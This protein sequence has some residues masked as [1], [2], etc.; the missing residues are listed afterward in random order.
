VWW[1]DDIIDGGAGDDT[2]AGV[3]TAELHNLDLR[4]LS[5]S[6]LIAY[7]FGMPGEPACPKQIF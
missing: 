5:P 7:I 1:D 6:G 3:G 2:L 4:F